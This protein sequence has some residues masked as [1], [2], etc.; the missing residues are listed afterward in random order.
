MHKVIWQ[1]LAISY[2]FSFQ[3]YVQ[4]IAIFGI[5]TANF[6]TDF[7]HI[8]I[9]FLYILIIKCL[10]IITVIVHSHYNHSDFQND[11]VISQKSLIY[12]FS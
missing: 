11:G 4:I 2:R 7:V 12:E 10:F 8:I 3:Q 6:T 9:I 1:Y 5:N